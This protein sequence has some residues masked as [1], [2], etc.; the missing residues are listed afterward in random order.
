M[1]IAERLRA[2]R[3]ARRLSQRELAEAVGV[4]AGLISHWERG[5]P[6]PGRAT[7][8][9]PDA[10]QLQA[11]AGALGVPAAALLDDWPD[12]S[13]EDLLRAC[14]L[15]RRLGPAESLSR[16]LVLRQSYPPT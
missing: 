8:A 16:L 11:L 2:C 4:T 6:R 13:T 1:G 9:V 7:L 3:E 12:W 10:T 14:D 15:L 5:A